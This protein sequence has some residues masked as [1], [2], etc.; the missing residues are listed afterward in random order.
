MPAT[1]THLGIAG[2]HAG[3]YAAVLHTAAHLGIA[4]INTHPLKR[5]VDGALKRAASKFPTGGQTVGDRIAREAIRRALVFNTFS[6]DICLARR[7]RGGTAAPGI[8]LRSGREWVLPEH[9]TTLLGWDSDAMGRFTGTAPA[10]ATIENYIAGIELVQPDLYMTF[11]VIGDLAATRRNYELLCAAFPEDARP[12]GRMW[13]V[14]PATATW[15]PDARVDHVRLPTSLRGC[16]HLGAYIPINATQRRWSADRLE[17]MANAVVA[18]AQELA[19]NPEFRLLVERH[20]KIALG[21]MAVKNAPIPRL[22]RHL[23][24]AVLAEEFPDVQFWLLG[25]AN[26]FVVNGIGVLGLL[27]RAFLDGTWAL[28][29]AMCAKMAYLDRGLITMLNVNQGRDAAGQ[30]IADLFLP[31]DWLIAGNLY[32]LLGAY[33]GT[34][35]W[36]SVPFPM[37]L[38]DTS[39]VEVIE[40]SLWT[41]LQTLG[42]ASPLAH[43][44]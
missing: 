26:A 3:R 25:Q 38:R 21:G 42:A 32:A 9:R 36:P 35:H 18:N 39:T 22:A 37:D 23:Y 6:Y 15:N 11:D 44:A 5:T 43:A 33:L 40:D 19:R 41:A 17:A 14:W 4:G 24:V 7:E 1:I 13:A 28:H 31:R 27:D 12:G 34:W 20:G 30:L 2:Q 10:W 8:R 16:A 29:E